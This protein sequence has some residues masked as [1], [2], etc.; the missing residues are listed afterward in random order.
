MKVWGSPEGGSVCER[1][2][3]SPGPWGPR[4]GGSPRLGVMGWRPSPWS[5]AGRTERDG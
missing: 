4:R 1:A 5:T 3:T 2:P